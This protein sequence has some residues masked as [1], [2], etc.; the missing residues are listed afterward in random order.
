LYAKWEEKAQRALMAEWKRK[1]GKVVARLKKKYGGN[2]SGAPPPRPSTGSGRFDAVKDFDDPFDNAFWAEW[3]DDYVGVLTDV[4]AEG[5]LIGAQAGLEEAGIA[6]DWKLVNKRARDWA[7]LYAADLVRRD[8]K[9]FDKSLTGTDIQN[10][11]SELA[12]WIDSPETF[13]DLV[14]RMTGVVEDPTRGALIAATE[15]TRTYAAGTTLGWETTGL[16]DET[17]MDKAQEFFPQHP[18][19]R[20]WPTLRPGQG[21]F[22]RTAEDELVCPICQPLANTIIVEV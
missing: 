14:R 22:F 21:V 9:R 18:G 17:A 3:E 16:I 6:I 4:L 19:C 8:S 2:K 5:A 11:R 13:A 15:S 7:R 10:I 12:K 1:T 20:C